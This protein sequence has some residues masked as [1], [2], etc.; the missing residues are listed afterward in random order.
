MFAGIGDNGAVDDVPG[1]VAGMEA[2]IR[3]PDAD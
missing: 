3:L 1:V 2:S